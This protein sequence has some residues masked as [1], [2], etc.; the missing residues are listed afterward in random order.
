MLE[1]SHSVQDS[2]ISMTTIAELSSKLQ[3]LMTK[4]A[5]RVARETGF[6]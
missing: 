2:Q 3:R 6:I 5:D 4:V 1:A